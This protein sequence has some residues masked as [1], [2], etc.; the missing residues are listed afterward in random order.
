MSL[1]LPFTLE[2]NQIPCSASQ[3]TD[4]GFFR[5]FTVPTFR[6]S[7]GAAEAAVAAVVSTGAA[8]L[9]SPPHAAARASAVSAH[10]DG[11]EMGMRDIV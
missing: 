10:Q 7:A 6:A 9:R 2:T 11:M 5:S 8:S 4:S 3:R 1:G